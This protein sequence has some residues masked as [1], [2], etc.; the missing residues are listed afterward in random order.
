MPVLIWRQGPEAMFAGRRVETA[1]QRIGPARALELEAEAYGM[2]DGLLAALKGAPAEPIVLAA[3]HEIATNWLRILMW[4]AA[5]EKGPCLALMDRD[6]L[7][8]FSGGPSGLLPDEEVPSGGLINRLRAVAR[9]G[10]RAVGRVR[11]LP[12][13]WRA[14]RA[15]RGRETVVLTS[16]D[17]G[18]GINLRP[19]EAIEKE[20]EGLGCG[21]LVLSETALV[22]DRARE[23]GRDNL[24]LIEG[25]EPV[26]ALRLAV[27]LV[28]E[29]V[30]AGGGAMFPS[31][32]GRALQGMLARFWP[33]Y[34]TRFVRTQRV[35]GIVGRWCRIRSVLSI[36]EVL[37]VSVAAGLWA[38]GKGI[39]WLGHFTAT[40]GRCPDHRFFPADRQLAYGGQLK[41]HVLD[42]RPDAQ[43]EVVGCPSFDAHLG[44][45]RQ[46]DREAM[47]KEFSGLGT[48][49]LVVVA[50]EA[51]ADPETELVPILKGVTSLA[52]VFCVLKVHPDD[53][54]AVM[55]ELV[56]SAGVKGRVVLVTNA[57]LGPLLGAADLLVCVL[58]T[59]I[60]EAAIMGTPS[61]SCDF[62]NKT[63]VLDFVAEGLCPGCLS[64]EDV[65][66]M[67]RDILFDAQIRQRVIW[68]MNSNISRFNGP[69]DGRSAYRIAALA[70][71]GNREGEPGG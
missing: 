67:V 12:A 62:S 34:V 13:F 55:E 70:C 23:R 15:C 5:M 50:S 14:L 51:F 43:V 30:N 20:I 60:I 38:R 65:A 9:F 21:T 36:S 10:K 2:A 39:A 42:V 26:I 49:K 11:K 59:I 47:E 63:R 56:R 31:D 6:V 1:L 54:P 68:E 8:A 46:A 28:D 66:P 40:I 22:R 4:Y 37:P 7:A 61:L 58:S 32:L 48:Q 27:P 44:R 64:P 29:L 52:G 71:R 45:D 69:N 16:N 33:K 19:L 25:D 17:S 24:V 41:D 53:D 3:Y 57:P 18:S 35:M